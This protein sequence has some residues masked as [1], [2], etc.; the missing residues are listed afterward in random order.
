MADVYLEKEP[1]MRNGNRPNLH[2]L[3]QWQRLGLPAVLLRLCFLFTLLQTPSRSSIIANLA[4]IPSPA[5][6]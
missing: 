6:P 1:H 5:M 3:E 2:Y 4:H